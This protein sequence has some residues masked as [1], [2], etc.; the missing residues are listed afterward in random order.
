MTGTCLKPAGGTPVFGPVVPVGIDLGNMT[1]I[2][3]PDYTGMHVSWVSEE[4]GEFRDWR[5]NSGLVMR[6][7]SIVDNG[8]HSS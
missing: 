2:V 1:F 8:M 6:A 7:R 4:R 3:I 5:M